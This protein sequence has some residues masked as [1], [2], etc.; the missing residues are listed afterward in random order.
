MSKAKEGSPELGP[1][2][3]DLRACANVEKHLGCLE[4]VSQLLT[5]FLAHPGMRKGSAV[6]WAR[7]PKGPGLS[8]HLYVT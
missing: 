5:Y 8:K 4:H 2:N 6:Y 3:H 7:M 1:A